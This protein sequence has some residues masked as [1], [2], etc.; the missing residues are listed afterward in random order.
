MDKSPV[1]GHIVFI[2]IKP[3]SEAPSQ[4]HFCIVSLGE[5]SSSSISNQKC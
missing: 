5:I 1:F 4:M 3:F 2:L